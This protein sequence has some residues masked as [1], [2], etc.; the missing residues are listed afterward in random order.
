MTRLASSPHR[1]WRDVLRTNRGEID[2]A[3]GE[4]R[5]LL[6]HLQDHLVTGGLQEE[7]ARAEELSATITEPVN[8]S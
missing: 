1:I 3:L 7:F 2:H 6:E 4:F 5:E 8:I